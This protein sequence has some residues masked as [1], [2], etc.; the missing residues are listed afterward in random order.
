MC[1]SN[2]FRILLAMPVQPNDFLAKRAPSIEISLLISGYSMGTA[3]MVPYS[4]GRKGSAN[5]AC[6]PKCIT[7]FSPPCTV[8]TLGVPHA[9][10]SMATMPNGSYL[11]DIENTAPHR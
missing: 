7:S 4:R 5:K 2:I 8:T 1:D 6:L 9:M 10:A 11:D 3:N